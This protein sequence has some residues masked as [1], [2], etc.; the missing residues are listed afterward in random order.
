MDWLH[1]V[2]RTFYATPE[3]FASDA[4]EH[5]V[6]RRIS[7]AVFPQMSFGD[8]VF[9]FQK[10]K[11]GSLLFGSFKVRSVWGAFSPRLL[12]ELSARG[13]LGMQEEKEESIC[14]PCG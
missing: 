3:E 8:R 2:G 10:D 4:K 9:L 7:P 14:R 11:G 1:F 5:Q 13:M 6:S 12:R